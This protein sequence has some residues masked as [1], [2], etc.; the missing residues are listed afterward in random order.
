MTIGD[1]VDDRALSLQDAGHLLVDRLRREQVVRRHGILLADPMAA[2][3]GLVMARRRPVELDERDVRR[4][5]EREARDAACIEQTISAGPSERWKSSTAA[6]RREVVA[7]EHMRGAGEA[8]DQ[9]LLDLAVMREHD[10][11]LTRRG[12]VLDPG[13][14]GPQLCR[15]RRAGAGSSAARAARRA[16]P[17][18]THIV[19]YAHVESTYTGTARRGALPA[20]AATRA[21]VRPIGGRRHPRSD[22]R[23]VSA[24]RNDPR[25]GA[26]ALSQRPAT[27]GQRPATGHQA[28]HPL[29]A[30]APRAM[31]RVLLDA[32]VFVHA[33][34]GDPVLRP[35]C[36]G[37]IAHLAAGR[38]AGEASSLMVEEVVHVRHRRNG[39]RAL[40]VR[41][42]RAAAALLTLHPVE[43]QV[44]EGALEAFAVHER[45]EVRDAVHIT[46]ARR[47]GLTIILS[48]DRGF[49]GIADVRRV[50]PAD[51][52]A[53]EALVTA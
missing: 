27:R 53:V 18:P 49:D 3:L 23:R 1:G 26:R 47:H 15:P 34:G 44:L 51:H 28:R 30:R 24:S 43:E 19:W 25:R 38:L 17:P 13:D 6:A 29:Q 16:A 52:A 36:Q 12:E 46:T 5:H 7:A 42:G 48:T 2:I 31:T 9:R 21:G 22:R 8:G 4:A 41:D 11:R 32:N 20:L 39:D 50:D 14:R 35:A 37:V 10:E 45:L 33:V 40:A